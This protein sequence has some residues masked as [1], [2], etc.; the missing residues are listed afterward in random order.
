MMEIVEPR[1]PAA[2]D[3]PGGIA[4]FP[5]F[6]VVGAPR[7]GTT[8]LSRYLSQHPEV[9]FS[10]PKEPHYFAR[11]D[12]RHLQGAEWRSEYARFFAHHHEGHRAVGE[13]SVSYLYFEETLEYITRINP[14][15]RLIAMLRNPLE[16]LPSY[17]LRMLYILEEDVELFDTAW[18]LQEA[19]V[20]GERIPKLCTDPR[21]LLYGE[22]GKLGE[23]VDR[24]LRVA[25]RE[26]CLVLLHDDLVRD[27]RS[28]YRQV[29]RFIGVDGDDRTEFPSRQA[30]RRYRHRWL[31]RLLYKPPVVYESLFEERLARAAHKAKGQDPKDGPGGTRRKKSLP[32][33]LHKRLRKWNRVAAQPRPLDERMR[34]LLREYFA[35]DVEKLAKLIDRDLGHWL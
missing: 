35:A 26:K 24:M 6:F 3:A 25:G 34:A 11:I 19:R 8:A 7:C 12:A 20:R 17:H 1:P 33:R 14:E 13:G 15:A 30:S 23:Q 5:D 21:L 10:K 27:P 32:L 18:G 4:P 28:V 2:S 29:L 31:Q 9:C 16:M 22:I